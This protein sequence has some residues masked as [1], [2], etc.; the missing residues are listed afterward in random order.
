MHIHLT[1]SI[2]YHTNDDQEFRAVET[3]NG[4]H[5]RQDSSKAQAKGTS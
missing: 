3:T 2:Q 1:H 4:N 5:Q